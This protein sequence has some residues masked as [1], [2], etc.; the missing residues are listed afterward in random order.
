M[1]Q[2]IKLP[3]IPQTFSKRPF[4][5][6]DRALLQAAND[7]FAVPIRI[8]KEA[9]VAD[10]PEPRRFQSEPRHHKITSLPPAGQNGRLVAQQNV[11]K[12]NYTAYLPTGVSDNYNGKPSPR[13]HSLPARK[14]GDS[15]RVRKV[16][17]APGKENKDEVAKV[18]AALVRSRMGE[19]EPGP[20]L[21][22]RTFGQPTRAQEEKYIKSQRFATSWAEVRAE[23]PAYR[24]HSPGDSPSA[25]RSHPDQ[26]SPRVGSKI[27]PDTYWDTAT[28][29][30]PNQPYISN[31]PKTWR[32]R[33]RQKTTRIKK[34]R[35][36][37]SLPTHPSETSG[38]SSMNEDKLPS[39][40]EVDDDISPEMNASN[41]GEFSPRTS[42]DRKIS[43]A[44]KGS[45][46]QPW[47]NNVNI[48]QNSKPEPK[49]NSRRYIEGLTFKPT[50][51]S[52]DDVYNAYIGQ[53]ELGDGND[54]GMSGSEEEEYMS[55][56][57]D[58]NFSRSLE[59][60]PQRGEK[61]E[62]V[63]NKREA[64]KYIKMTGVYGSD[65]YKN[66]R[67]EWFLQKLAKAQED[68]AKDAEERKKMER[69]KREENKERQQR[70]L[71]E[72]RQR[73]R[74]EQVHRFRTQYV[75]SRVLEHE[76]ANRYQYG[77]PEDYEDGFRKE[78]NQSEFDQSKGGKEETSSKSKSTDKSKSPGPKFQ[79][80]G[81][82]PGA[83][84]SV[85]RGRGGPD[86]NHDPQKQKAEE[87]REKIV[88]N[89][90][91][92]YA[93]MASS[94]PNTGDTENSEAIE[95]TENSRVQDDG[96]QKEINEERTDPLQDRSSY[97]KHEK[98]SKVV[99]DTAKRNNARRSDKDILAKA[100]K[101]EKRY[102]NNRDKKKPSNGRP[103]GEA[104]PGPQTTQPSKN[105]NSDKPA[106]TSEDNSQNHQGVSADSPNKTSK[107][108][109]KGGTKKAESPHK[110]SKTNIK[111]MGETNQNKT[112][113]N[114]KPSSQVFREKESDK[115]ATLNGKNDVTNTVLTPEDQVGESKE[116]A[117][118]PKI[119][120]K[121]LV[122]TGHYRQEK[123]KQ[124]HDLN[125]VIDRKQD[126]KVKGSS[127]DMRNSQNG[128]SSVSNSQTRLPAGQVKPH[129]SHLNL[130]SKD[131]PKDKEKG[132]QMKDSN[133]ASAKNN[134]RSNPTK[135]PEKDNSP[136]KT[137]NKPAS[138]QLSTKEPKKN[139]EPKEVPS[140]A[141]KKN[142]GVAASLSQGARPLN[143]QSSS[144]R[145]E[146]GTVAPRSQG[147]S[148]TQSG[149]PRKVPVSSDPRAKGKAGDQSRE[150]TAGRGGRSSKE[151]G[152]PQKKPHGNA[153]LASALFDVKTGPS[154]DPKSKIPKME[155]IDTVVI[156]GK[157]GKG[158]VVKRK[159]NVK[160]V[161]KEADNLVKGT[162]TDTGTN[163][164]TSRQRNSRM[165]SPD[166]TLG[167]DFEV[168]D[169]D[170]TEDD[171]FERLRKKYNIKIDSDE[172]DI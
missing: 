145:K 36:A 92:W 132:V 80:K 104:A 115:S 87:D 31:R 93:D 153:A 11:S 63:L 133:L 118:E 139:Q 165:A 140:P 33:P 4:E 65:A 124:Y 64:I 88:K 149:Q 108:I 19:V 167:S 66:Q 99:T 73:F 83:A 86:Q 49:V 112:E 103:G 106:V 84:K 164:G 146:T 147:V 13:Q 56:A 157:D 166:L 53:E 128:L 9:R 144:E 170:E 114:A 41:D 17:S 7:D 67:K 47:N 43:P 171:I 148:F 54:S 12:N 168:D 91:S 61:G 125:H 122:Y 48:V 29:H 76:H 26:N 55:P 10:R 3:H 102:T 27:D 156:Q 58:S 127:N 81:A 45:K 135:E 159:K 28:R 23:N 131:E 25:H 21:Q 18:V 1:Q 5:G 130:S 72:V 100:E 105:K 96:L 126:T 101:L 8:P 2:T 50:L 71:K 68:K 150:T 119:N 74:Q 82:K 37:V 109:D 160:D 42:V 111:N 152:G 163:R 113:E 35:H 15:G 16:N 136:R 151:R 138:V 120:E 38:T 24:S 158:R 117:K 57:E 79:S 77:L 60:S 107:E 116:K 32:S 6:W 154:W 123:D 75:T 121:E 78:S 14:P 20:E 59:N 22:Q 162:Q 62:R 110:P 30:R 70:Q 155:G 95:E 137:Q 51:T 85:N 142:T 44:A 89:Q 46:K 98:D 94:Q 97:D 129:D 134:V 161:V 169:E 34:Q 143:Q 39:D 69:R 40:D 172:E 52:K 141:L 90:Q